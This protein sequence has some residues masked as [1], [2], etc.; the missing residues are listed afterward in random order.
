MIFKERFMKFN[1]AKIKLIT[2]GVLMGV[3][4]LLLTT[5]ALAMAQT[6]SG[7][8]RLIPIVGPGSIGGVFELIRGVVKWVYIL[9]F[10]LAVFFIL[11]AAFTYLRAGGNPENVSKAKNMLI[12]A[13][14]AI[15][16]AFMAVGLANIILVFLGNPNA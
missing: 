9:F 7:L 4:V 15:V 3:N 10:I 2:T 11:M 1:P 16:I 6:A 14:I 12:Y 5:G 13:A 8:D